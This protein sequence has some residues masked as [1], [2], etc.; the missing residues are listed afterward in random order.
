VTFLAGESITRQCRTVYLAP[1][2]NKQ[3]KGTFNDIVAA[4]CNSTDLCN[5]SGR[6]G[7]ISM[8]MILLPAFLALRI[9]FF[10]GL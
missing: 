8:M 7:E 4:Y 1:V 9:S 2:E 5:G 10:S 6:L 3:V